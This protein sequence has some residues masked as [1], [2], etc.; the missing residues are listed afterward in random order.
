MLFSEIPTTTLWCSYSEPI[1][2]TTEA[3]FQGS[4]R[5]GPPWKTGKSQSLRV[6]LICHDLGLGENTRGADSDWI[7]SP[8]HMA[9]SV[10]GFKRKT[11]WK[12][13]IY[14]VTKTASFYVFPNTIFWITLSELHFFFLIALGPQ[15]DW[16]PNEAFG[17]PPPP[18]WA[19]ASVRC[20]LTRSGVNEL[21]QGQPSLLIRSWLTLS[22]S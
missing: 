16:Y 9:P 22:I 8:R 2:E 21:R 15:D 12:T 1:T 3:P 14:S 19:A 11:L 17:L 13:C 4:Q 5:A 10:V 7:L 6:H 18:D 20:V